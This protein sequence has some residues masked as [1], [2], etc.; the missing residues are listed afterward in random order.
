LPN[1]QTEFSGSLMP[2]VRKNLFFALGKND[3]KIYIVPSKDLV[4]TRIG[5]AA[6]TSN[7]GFSTVDVELWRKINTL[8][9]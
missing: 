3:Q 2:Y 4:I 8:I 6:V 9:E 7:F 5:E 1:S